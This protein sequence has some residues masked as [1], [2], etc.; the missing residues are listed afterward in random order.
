MNLIDRLKECE[1]PESMEATW[2]GDDLVI[3][4]CVTVR[5]DDDDATGSALFIVRGLKALKENPPE[6]ELSLFPMLYPIRNCYSV[7][8]FERKHA[9]GTTMTQAVAEALIASFGTNKKSPPG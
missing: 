7:G 9:E 6:L 5:L 8:S 1:L 2:Y 4:N 3:G